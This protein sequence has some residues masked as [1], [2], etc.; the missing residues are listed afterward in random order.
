M[1]EPQ[2]HDRPYLLPDAPAIPGKIKSIPDDFVVEEVPLYEPIDQGTHVFFMIEKRELATMRAIND[3]ARALNVKPQDIGAAGLKDAN[4][5]TRQILS[6]EHIDP[7]RIL[8]LDIPRIQ[9][10][11]ARHHTNK[12]KIGHLRGNR[13]AI[14]LRGPSDSHLDSVRQTMTVLARRG[15]PNYFGPQRFGMRG[16]TW[17]IGLAL[18]RAD[19]PAAART[20]LG[21]PLPIDGGDLLRARQLYEAGDYESAAD[22]WPPSFRTE[23]HLLRVLHKWGGDHDRALR[24]VHKKTLNF[25]LSAFQS[26]LFNHILAQRIDRM[27]QLLDGDLA[28]KHDNGAVFSV[29]DAQV[30]QSRCDAFDVSPSGPLFGHKMTRPAGLPAEMEQAALDQENLIIEDFRK[31][32]PARLKG[33][34]RPLRF[35]PK[36]WGVSAGSDDLGPYLLFEFFLPAG[37]YATTLLREVCHNDCDRDET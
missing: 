8:D 33:A 37:C 21:N 36:D 12:L 3:V 26:Y 7:Q 13:F 9:I 2:A 28:W 16:D 18:L 32:R 5:V 34:R 23:K 17:Q 4:A 11:W 15:V 25:Y 22:A 6:V 27:D 24:S 35:Q 30:E 10:L 20:L 19:P 1:T 29:Q 14:K 31:S